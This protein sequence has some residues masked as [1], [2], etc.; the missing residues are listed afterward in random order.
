M[1]AASTMSRRNR[2]Q[3]AFSLFA[4]QDII[5]SVTG[6]MILVTLI[7][8]LEL[9]QRKE[10]QAKDDTETVTEE[11]KASIAD[12]EELDRTLA[13]NEEVIKRIKKQIESG[14]AQLSELAK[15]DIRQVESQIKNMKEVNEQ[16]EKDKVRLEMSK[17]ETEKRLKELEQRKQQRADDPETLQNLQEKIR[18]MEEELKKLKDENRV[19]YNP[20]EGDSKQPMLVQFEGEQIMTAKMGS[21]DGTQTFAS[22]DDFYAWAVRQDSNSIYFVLL[23]KPQGIENFLKLK[24]ALKSEGF[25]VGSDLLQKDQTALD[26]GTGGAT[27]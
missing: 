10:G 16:F 25:D 4:F 15:Y 21:D 6:I 9:L 18:Q 20:A 5:T 17:E 19:V 7:L 11:I 14:Q 27:P 23:V 26:L 13:E 3:T 22:A 12:A 24:T 1:T 2:N 8:A